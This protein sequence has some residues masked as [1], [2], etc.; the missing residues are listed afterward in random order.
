M[1]QE[2]LDKMKFGEVWK[3]Q[4]ALGVAKGDCGVVR[5]PCR[6]LLKHKLVMAMA[7]AMAMVVM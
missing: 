5:P 7:T 3:E 2:N 1:D 6:T 4:Y